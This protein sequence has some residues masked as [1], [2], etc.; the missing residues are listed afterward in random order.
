M[1]RAMAKR[2]AKRWFVAEFRMGETWLIQPAGPVAPEDVSPSGA[3][4]GLL[5]GK[6]CKIVGPSQH[7]NSSVVVDLEGRVYDIHDSHL[8]PGEPLA[9]PKHSPLNPE[10]DEV[11]FT[12]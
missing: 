3:P 10:L 4:I 5:V 7:F 12:V 6:L 11:S 2:V 1:S 8:I 9:P